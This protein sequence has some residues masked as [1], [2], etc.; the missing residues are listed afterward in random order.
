MNQEKNKGF[1]IFILV[2]G[3]I[4]YL[5]VFLIQGPLSLAPSFNGVFGQILVLISTVIVVTNGKRGFIAALILN[6]LTTLSALMSTL[7]SQ[8][9]GALPG[10]ITPIATILT[11]TIIFVYIDRSRKMHAELNESYEQM[12]EQNRVMKEKDD[13]L[14][15]LAYYDRMTT[16]PNKQR[17]LDDLGD[18]VAQRA[19]FTVITADVDDFKRINDAYGHK[20]GDD[21][22]RTYAERIDKYSGSRYTVA[23]TGG[24]EFGIILDGTP[25]EADILNIIEQLRALFGEPVMVNGEPVSV[26]MCY[27]V[28]AHPRDGAD[29]ELLLDC[30]DAA[31]YSAKL[32]GKN[33][34]CFYSQPTA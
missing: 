5:A 7:R 30:A 16:L 31:I 29:P 4:L 15:Y 3:I 14:T 21:V 11:V 1:N 28:A 26:N 18:R 8:N 12:I 23:R 25:T 13:A 10:I 32:G 33:R 2:V 19:P 22:I 17:F 9:M 24:D 20:A 27:G 6:G 34:T